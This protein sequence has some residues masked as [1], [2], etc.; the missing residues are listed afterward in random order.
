MVKSD[1]APGRIKFKKALFSGTAAIVILVLAEIILHLFTPPFN[2]SYTLKL[3]ESFLDRHTGHMP[4]HDLFWKLTP[5]FGGTWDGS[6]ISINSHGLRDVDFPQIKPDGVFR[7]LSL[8]ESGTFGVYVNPED[9]YNKVLEQLLNQNSTNK[10]YQ[11]INA[12]VSSYTSFQGARYLETKGMAL[13]PD[14]VLVYFGQNDTLPTYFEDRVTQTNA[15]SIPVY[16]RGFTDKQIWQMRHRG[17]NA[18][19]LFI[20][21]ALYRNLASIVCWME[22]LVMDKQELAVPRVPPSDRKENY[23][24][25]YEIAKSGGAKVLYLTTPYFDKPIEPPTD[26]AH[27]QK[28]H[29]CNLWK[30]IR[31]EGSTYREMFSDDVHP[32]QKGHD[33]IG[34]TIF[35]CLEDSKLLPQK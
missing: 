24:R 29:V 23:R 27:G 4:D 28:I 1:M 17:Q 8:G 31:R 19:R 7:I 32:K 21:S 18:R 35:E 33:L 5:G 11:V 14:I 3:S 15:F 9:T 20:K 6:P 13:E 25:I 10:R 2:Q 34:L 12:G 30:G 22:H 16:G 26:L